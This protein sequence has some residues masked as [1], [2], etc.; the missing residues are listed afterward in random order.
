MQ[1]WLFT[2]LMLPLL[3]ACSLGLDFWRPET[4][5]QKTL[6]FQNAPTEIGSSTISQWW[7]RIDDPNLRDY[8]DQLVADNLSLKQA[9]ARVFQARARLGIE[10]GGFTPSLSVN[11]SA[12]RSFTPG[13][14]TGAINTDRQYATAYNPELSASWEIDLF[15][16]IRRSVES[17][18]ATFQAA[19]YDEQALTHS[20]IADLVNRR[21]AIAVNTRL[22]SLAKENAQN[23]KTIF[24]LVQSRYELGV[25]GADLDDVLLAEE[26][27]TTIKADTHEFQ[28]RLTDETYAFD[29]LLGQIPGTTDGVKSTFPMIPAPLDIPI[30][31]PANLLDRRP[32]LRASELRLKAAKAD[33]GVALADLYPTV[34]LSTALGFTGDST[35]NLF[36]ADQLAGSIIGALTARI[37]EGGR[38]RANIDLPF[39]A[40]HS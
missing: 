26:N 14:S 37:F 15:G 36:S 24:D 12:Y 39:L 1:R 32:D 13:Q 10:R 34:N 11:T 5:A 33:I 3:S 31:V 29:V 20:L 18:D 8:V 2:I 27:Y 25:R 4:A 19:L 40:S 28:R 35:N 23:R 21:I 7:T 17:A 30:C 38:L 16:R 6:Q 9:G 22:L